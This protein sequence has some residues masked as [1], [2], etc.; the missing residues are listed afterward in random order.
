V[1]VIPESLVVKNGK[2]IAIY[3]EKEIGGFAYHLMKM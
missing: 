1:E 2:K 3:L